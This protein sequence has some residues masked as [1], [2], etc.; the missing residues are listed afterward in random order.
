MHHSLGL[1]DLAEFT[2]TLG[3]HSGNCVHSLCKYHLRSHLTR[4]ETRKCSSS[5]LPASSLTH[6]SLQRHLPLPARRRRAH[7][8]CPLPVL[9][10]YRPESKTQEQRSTA[11][12]S[13]LIPCVGSEHHKLGE[14]GEVGVPSALKSSQIANPVASGS[15]AAPWQ[16]GPDFLQP[17]SS[18]PVLSCVA[19]TPCPPQALG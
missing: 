3:G 1:W 4:P 19:Q 14:A 5:V 8:P 2:D 17:Q 12:Y 16:C 6:P 7:A 15:P 9:R 13:R 10:R 11:K 18:V